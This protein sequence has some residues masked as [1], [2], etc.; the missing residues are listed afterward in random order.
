MYVDEDLAVFGI[1]KKH[2][3]AGRTFHSLPLGN[4]KSSNLSKLIM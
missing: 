2:S 3:I 4:L 1:D